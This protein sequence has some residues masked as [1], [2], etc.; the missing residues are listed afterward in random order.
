MIRYKF[1][2]ERKDGSEKY[3][4]VEPYLKLENVVVD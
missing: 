1:Y 4:K 3:K 2:G